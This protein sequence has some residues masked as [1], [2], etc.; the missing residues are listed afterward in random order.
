[1]IDYDLSYSEESKLWL[2][3]LKDGRGPGGTGKTAD[4]AIRRLKYWVNFFAKDN[5]RGSASR[6]LKKE[7]KAALKMFAKSKAKAGKRKRAYGSR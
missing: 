5:R 1:M 7:S 2:A 3:R 4:G 6:S